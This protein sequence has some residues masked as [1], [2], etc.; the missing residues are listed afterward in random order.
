MKKKN[1]QSIQ[2]INKFLEL[3]L[4]K[5]IILTKINFFLQFKIKS[6]KEKKKKRKKK[7]LPIFDISLNRSLTK[8]TTNIEKKK[9]LNE[10]I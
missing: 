8:I 2:E 7:T 6:I 3:N 4:M 5:W 10:I 9:E 1:I